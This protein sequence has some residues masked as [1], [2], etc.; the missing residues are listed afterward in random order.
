MFQLFGGTGPPI[1]R[2]AKFDNEILLREFVLKVTDWH[3]AEI[4]IEFGGPKIGGLIVIIICDGA[5]LTYAR[6]IKTTSLS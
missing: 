2:A 3:N 5:T 1:W 4:Y 6:R